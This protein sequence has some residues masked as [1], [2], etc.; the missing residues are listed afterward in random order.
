VP[1]YLTYITAQVKGGRIAYLSDV[2]GWDSTPPQFG[3]L[4]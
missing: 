1:I 2:Y 3:S 4:N